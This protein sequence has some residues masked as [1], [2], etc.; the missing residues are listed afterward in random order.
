MGP[1][2]VR[3]THTCVRCNKLYCKACMVS[4]EAHTICIALKRVED[5]DTHQGGTLRSA[6]HVDKSGTAF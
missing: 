1:H 4:P 2:V 6:D 3:I 5:L